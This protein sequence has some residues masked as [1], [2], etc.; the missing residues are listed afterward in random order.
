MEA[1][2]DSKGKA[3]QIASS[4]SE[5]STEQFTK[6]IRGLE[7]TANAILR[8]S[9]NAST[10]ICTYADASAPSIIFAFQVFHDLY[11][12]ARDRGAKIR[13]LTEITKENIDYCRRL[14][15]ELRIEVRHLD[16]VKGNFTVT[17]KEYI[18]LATIKENQSIQQVI[19]SNL[20][21]IVEQNQF[22][23]DS[24]WERAVPAKQKI[25]EIDLGIDLG[26]TRF[27]YDR[28]EILRTF[29]DF[30]NTTTRE[31]LVIVPSDETPSRNLAL[32]Q[33]LGL[34]AREKGIRVCALIPSKSIASGLQ[35]DFEKLKQDLNLQGIEFK[36][37]ETLSCDMSI[38]IFDRMKMISAQFV[39][40]RS[41]RS[42]PSGDAVSATITTNAESI[43]GMAS[44]FDALW[45]ENELWE[46]ETRSRKQAEL[47]QDILA[48]DIRNYNQVMKLSMELLQ[49]E[50]PD[51]PSVRTV[52]DAMLR[53]IDS[54]TELVQRARQ[55][56]RILA[57]D[58][59]N[60]FPVS[61]AEAVE[62]SLSLVKS[63]MSTK[64]F[65]VIKELNV[66]EILNTKESHVSALVMADE[67]LP[68]VFVNLYSNAVKYTDEK[69]IGIETSFEEAEEGGTAY[70]K[71]SIADQGRGI[72]NEM[73][74]HVFTRYLNT[75]RG[76]GLGLS[77]VHALVVGRY[78]GKI[79]VIDRKPKGT[80]MEVWLP[81][82]NS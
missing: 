40:P 39:E 70:W 2:Q 28:E 20:T 75:A 23:F 22:L 73:K 59:P 46:R 12:K 6:V 17:D 18:A 38:G 80:I 69:E 65:K 54:S 13:Y 15:K 31:A 10:S 76:T 61:L 21:Q 51:N 64:D 49:A 74:E 1:F 32:L 56:G 36:L 42:R 67:F 50:L 81:K 8:V 71:V 3:S 5:S 11:G 79:K 44:I 25:E 78:H 43:A 7:E 14:S 66:D 45:R 9:L 68:Q 4:Q 60:L 47:M 33:K 30:L 62:N 57:E 24:M 37:A 35:L 58:A 27:T 55:F 16:G 72:P 63:T 19:Y 34:K 48:H 77:I 29:D 82:A 41:L 53:A 52:G 26:Q